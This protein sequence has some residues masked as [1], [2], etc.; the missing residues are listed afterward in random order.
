M[1]ALPRFSEVEPLATD[2]RLRWFQTEV[3]GRRAVGAVGGGEGPPVVFLHGWAMGSHTYK[4]ALSRLVMRGCRV[5]APALPT[6]GGTAALALNETTLDGYARWVAKFIRAVG[7]EEPALLIGHSFGGGVAIKLA[8]QRPEMVSYLVL[9]NAIGGVSPRQP[10]EWAAGFAR[11]LWPPLSTLELARAMR[12]DLLPNFTGNPCGVLRTAI[13]AQQADLRT[14]AK[15]LRARGLPVLVLTGQGDEVVPRA[16]FETLCEA[17]GTDGRVVVGG[18][19]WMLADPDSLATAIAQVV[20]KEVDQYQRSRAA[21]L[22]S[23]LASLLATMRVPR[24]LAKNL[25]NN[26]P[27]LWL[28]S[29]SPAVLAADLAL[30]HPKLRPHEVRAVARP[31]TDSDSVRLTIV[32]AD[33]KG[34]LADSAGMLASNGLSIVQA[35]AATWPTRGLALHSLVV[36]GGRSL[37]SEAW[38]QLGRHLRVMAA[39]RPLPGVRTAAPERVTVHGGDRDQLLV[40]IKVRD[41]PGALSNLCRAFAEHGVNIESLRARSV[42]G[43]AVDT[44]LVSGVADSAEIPRIFDKRTWGAPRS[45]DPERRG[46]HRTW[47]PVQRPSSS[48]HLRVVVS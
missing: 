30:C 12:A 6:F 47:A 26:A 15:E 13:L 17:I 29:E 4:R 16:A 45:T 40:A 44:F 32:S 9:L 43:L 24:R 21:R 39:T 48:A 35:S 36:E 8:A 37:T 31:I 23:D 38:D 34:L 46:N 27:P 5:Y 28:L 3:D 22:S 14:D 1:A 25:I 2:E 18:H 11:E 19:S 41:E 42:D 20:D 10:W 7:I 33:R